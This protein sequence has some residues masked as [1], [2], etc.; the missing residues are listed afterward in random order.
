M[1]VERYR[2]PLLKRQMIGISF[3]SYE[4]ALTTAQAEELRDRLTAILDQ[5]VDQR[6]DLAIACS[7][8][9]DGCRGYI[10]FHPA[11]KFIAVSGHTDSG[12]VVLPSQLFNV[13]YTD[14]QL[15]LTVR[16]IGGGDDNQDES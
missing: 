1:N 6:A 3:G 11:G 7:C 5:P 16:Q 15:W 12:G 14:A 8:G 13:L 9:R 4:H 10:T 2:T